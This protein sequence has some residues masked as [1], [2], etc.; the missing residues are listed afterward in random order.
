M[1]V[2]TA[3]MSLTFTIRNRDMVN[4]I[5]IDLVS[6]FMVWGGYRGM[7]NAYIIVTLALDIGDFPIG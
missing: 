4:L 1:G 2:D 5:W 6:M 7:D 3:Y